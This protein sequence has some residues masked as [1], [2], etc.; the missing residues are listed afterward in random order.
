MHVP[1][2]NHR[3]LRLNQAPGDPRTF[4]TIELHGL[5]A[6]ELGHLQTLPP[7]ALRER[8]VVT[9]APEPGRHR[10]AGPVAPMLGT[11]QVE[12]AL[13]R[14]VP[15]FPLIPGQCYQ[16]RYGD[17]A[18]ELALASEPSVPVRVLGIYP[19]A[20]VLPENLL[21][22]YIV[23]SAPMREGQALAHLRLL[24]PQGT[25]MSGVFL[26][27]REE[28]WDRSGTRLTLLL[29]PARV[30]TGLGAHE[31]LGRAL[32]RGQHYRLVVDAAFRSADGQPLA[33]CFVK[34]FTIGP[35]VTRRL[36]S[37][38]WQLG[39]PSRAAG[40]EPLTLRF[41][42]AIDAAQTATFI[43]ICGPSGPLAGDSTIEEL[44]TVWCF[45][46]QMPWVTGDY[47]VEVDSRLEDC[48][49]NNLESAFDSPPLER[50]PRSVIVL[51]FTIA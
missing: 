43:R 4:G 29:D 36:P 18:A 28:L 35:A 45:T 12:D 26:D 31:Q 10:E 13:L 8:L 16:A 47:T 32:R 30:K 37:A 27:T 1:S 23:F 38:G 5:P 39:P 34:E 11:C 50:H 9:V 46:P 15:R 3:E 25:L 21:R 7:A 48:A 14:F 42:M 22:C 40:R 19:S 49:G 20:A 33:D 6:D 51:P 2:A 17:V 41:P 44:E 24:D